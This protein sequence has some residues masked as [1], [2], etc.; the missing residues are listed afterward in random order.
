MI[1]IIVYYYYY[2]F[3][4]TTTNT[5]SLEIYKLV[6]VPL[7]KF[8]YSSTVYTP[9]YQ[10]IIIISFV[11]GVYTY[12][13]ETNHVPKGYNVAAILLLLIM[14]SLLLVITLALMYFYIS[15]FR[16]MCAVFNMAV[17]FSSLTSWLLLLLLLLLKVWDPVNDPRADRRFRHPCHITTMPA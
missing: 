8:H 17:F 2:Y 11:Q 4:T 7:I 9:V 10:I 15:I 13:S 3:I 12:I 5:V 14:V 1:L 16:S 6:S